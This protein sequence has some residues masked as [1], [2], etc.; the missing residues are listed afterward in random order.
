MFN[1]G[2]IKNC[3]IHLSPQS[4]LNESGGNFLIVPITINYEKAPEQSELVA[5]AEGNNGNKMCV[6]RLFGWLRVSSS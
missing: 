4:C 2:L 1:N 3:S 6:F 5:E